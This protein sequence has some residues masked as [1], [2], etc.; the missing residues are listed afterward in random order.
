VDARRRGLEAE[1]DR[2]FAELTAIETQRRTG[3]LDPSVYEARR[4]ELVATLEGIYAAIDRE[5]A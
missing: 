2:L 3:T 1:R 5:A 4:R